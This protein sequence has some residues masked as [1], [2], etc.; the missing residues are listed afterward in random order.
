MDPDEMCPSA[1][2]SALFDER[3]EKLQ[4]QVAI[5]CEWSKAIFLWEKIIFNIYSSLAIIF[6]RS[7]LTLVEW[8][9]RLVV[10]NSLDFNFVWLK[11]FFL[12]FS[13]F[14]NDLSTDEKMRNETWKSIQVDVLCVF[15]SDS[16]QLS[17]PECLHWDFV[18]WRN[19]LSSPDPWFMLKDCWRLFHIEKSCEMEI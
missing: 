7:A 16:F 15:N 19:A 14:I 11:R 8:N 13:V 9:W 6:V 3:G 2:I 4:T 17:N 5:V 18:T 10:T 12:H 1:D